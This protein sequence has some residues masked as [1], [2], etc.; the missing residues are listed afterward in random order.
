M[1]ERFSFLC[2]LFGQAKYRYLLSDYQIGMERESLRAVKKGLLSAKPHPKSL[3]SALTNPLISTDFAEAQVEIISPTFLSFKSLETFT[4]KL[5]AFIASNLGEEYLWP[6]SMPCHLPDK[7]EITIA[8]YGTSD[9][10][11][12]KVYYRRGLVKRY[13]T[14]MQTISGIHYNFSFSKAFFTL[15]HK[16]FNSPLSLEDF[17]SDEYFHII[18]N[19]LSYDFI[20]TY[21]F[22]A[23]PVAHSSFF[24]K[25]PDGFEKLS[26]DSYLKKDATCL[27][28]SSYGYSNKSKCQLHPSLDN[29]ESFVKDLE[30]AIKTPCKSYEKI[31]LFNEKKERVQLNYN[32]LQIASEYYASIR[33]KPHIFYKETY[34]EA[35][36]QRGVKYLEVRSIDLDPFHPIGISEEQLH[37]THLFLLYCLFKENEPKGTFNQ[38]MQNEERVAREGNKKNISLDFLG[39]SIPLHECLKTI[40][41]EMEEIVSLFDKKTRAPYQRALRKQKLKVDGKLKTTSQK[42]IEALKFQDYLSLGSTLGKKHKETLLKQKLPKKLLSHFQKEAEQSL[43]KQAEI[44][45]KETFALKDYEDLELSTQLVL[46][47]CFKRGI[48]VLILDREDNILLLQDKKKKEIL[49]QATIT[50]Y[51]SS[52]SFHLLGNKQATKDL[53]Q[54]E[55]FSVAPGCKVTNLEEAEEF[56]KNFKGKDLVV[57]P[58]HTNCGIGISFVNT[59]KM[60]EVHKALEIALSYSSSALIEEYV[61]GAEY[62]V[63]II[64]HKIVGVLKREPASVIGDGISSIKEL[65]K[66]KNEDPKSFKTP[67]DHIKLHDVEK[68]TLKEAGFTIESILKKG[69]KVYLRKNSNVSTGGDAIDLTEEFPNF[70]KNV[71]LKAA[72]H[73]KVKICGVDLIIPDLSKETYYILEMNYNPNLAMHYYPYKGK[74]R[75]VA[76]LLL[77]FL[78]F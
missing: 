8:N 55:G 33:P 66:Q 54:K 51:D 42:V 44:E 36:K 6:F 61:K 15:L 49:K 18:R 41:D 72:D 39:K 23:S 43:V 2:S 60:K 9:T 59:K 78:G 47:E 37:F 45:L 26:S 67:K 53:L 1:N 4:Y 29:L 40:L 35:L 11:M 31:G 7:D 46:R 34:L 77:D 30:H 73:F 48:E 21:L 65:V 19:F 70:F 17:I 63:L 57:K 3:G 10:G 52:L 58:T 16:E 13:G 74:R 75:E 20:L 24:S 56:L 12:E 71:A 62:R 50:A 64:D 25:T 32:H 68:K 28:M 5:H 76:S 22:G 38:I 14:T 69:Q 27:R